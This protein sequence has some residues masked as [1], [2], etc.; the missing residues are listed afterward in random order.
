M[1]RVHTYVIEKAQVCGTCIFSIPRYNFCKLKKKN[2]QITVI[3]HEAHVGLIVNTFNNT[4]LNVIE[5][6]FY[7]MFS[8][9]C[10]FQE[11]FGNIITNRLNFDS[12]LFRAASQ[13]TC[14]YVFY[15]T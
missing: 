4:D 13:H 1:Y 5:T 6:V 2:P 12:D 7:D 3:I 8:V 9:C 14:L 10:G 11:Q 15:P